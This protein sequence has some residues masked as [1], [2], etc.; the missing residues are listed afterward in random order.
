MF[1]SS[2]LNL[3]GANP[4]NREVPAIREI[5]AGDGDFRFHPGQSSFTC[6]ALH[7]LNAV[8]MVPEAGAPTADVAATGRYGIRPI[9]ADVF[10]LEEVQPLPPLNTGPPEAFQVEQVEFAKSII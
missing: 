10:R 6:P 4:I 1:T 8:H 7:L 3:V 2:K 9:D 5:T